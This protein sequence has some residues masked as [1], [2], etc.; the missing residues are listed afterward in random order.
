MAA[1]EKTKS[2]QHRATYARDKKKGGYLIRVAGPH[3]NAFSG[4]EVPVILKDG[5]EQTETLDRLIWTG[6]DNETHEPVS[7]YSFIAKPKEAV[8]DIEF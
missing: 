5:S 6:T 3:S 2:R 8:E 1:K 7:L 4:R